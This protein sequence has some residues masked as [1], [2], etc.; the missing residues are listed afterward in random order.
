MFYCLQQ[1]DYRL[2][3][4]AIGFGDELIRM[5]ECTRDQ[6]KAIHEFQSVLRRLPS[7][8]NRYSAFYGFDLLTDD[9]D[10]DGVIRGW[11]VDIE[12]D[13]M[14]EIGSMYGFYNDDG[15]GE[16]EERENEDYI[17]YSPMSFFPYTEEHFQRWIEQV[18]DIDRWRDPHLTFTLDAEFMTIYE[19]PLWNPDGPA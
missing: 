6:A 12:L 16:W 9:P 3:E 2:I 13:G 15:S 18:K 5:P 4:A 14:I 1:C 11:Y 17:Y 19:L 8:P 7:L 10:Y